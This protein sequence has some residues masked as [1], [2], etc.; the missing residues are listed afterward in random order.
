MDGRQNSIPVTVYARWVQHR[1]SKNNV[2]EK[3]RMHK[4]YH[5]VQN[6]CH[7]VNRL[8]EIHVGVVRLLVPGSR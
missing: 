1:V 7:L 4:G 8:G 2:D 3:N 6:V 5:G